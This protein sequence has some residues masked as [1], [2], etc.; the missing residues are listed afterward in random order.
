MGETTLTKKKYQDVGDSVG[1]PDEQDKKHIQKLIARYEKANPG[2]IIA[3]REFAREHSAA[4][5]NEFGL[6]SGT[7]KGAINSNSMRYMMELPPKLHEMIE[8]YIP[9]IFRSKKH[10]AWFCKNFKFLMI[11]SRH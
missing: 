7:S 10:F 8:E 6:V 4:A 11:P 3:L 5:D 2:D 1:M 9:T